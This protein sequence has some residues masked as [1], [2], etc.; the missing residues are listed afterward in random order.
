[1]DNTEHNW[2]TP[3]MN[4]ALVQSLQTWVDL[5]YPNAVIPI[6]HDIDEDGLTDYVGLDSFGKLEL[7]SATQVKAVDETQSGYEGPAWVRA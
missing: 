1:M 4:E 2:L 3:E 6:Y 5:D 7:L